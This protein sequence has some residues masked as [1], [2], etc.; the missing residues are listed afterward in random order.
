MHLNDVAYEAFSIAR[1][2]GWHDKGTTHFERFAL[3]HSEVSEAFEAY[4]KNGQRNWAE[5]DGKPEGVA[6]ELADIII[7]CAE[8]AFWLEIDLDAAVECKM[9]YNKVRLDVPIHGTEKAI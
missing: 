7:R 4:R 6:S 8:L 2:A 5:V 3:I 9:E 1:V